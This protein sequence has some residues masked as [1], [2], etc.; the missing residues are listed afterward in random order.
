MSRADGSVQTRPSTHPAA[1]LRKGELGLLKFMKLGSASKA[2]EATKMSARMYHT[3]RW[4]EE[5]DALLRNMSAS[6]KSITL[7]TVK[8]NRPMAQI[9]ARAL[10]LEIGI[11]GTEIGKRRKNHQSA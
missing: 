4:T 2:L 6:G 3:Q 11:P 10:D 8:L 9:K 1:V 5:D 7:M